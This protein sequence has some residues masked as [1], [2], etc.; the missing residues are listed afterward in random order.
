MGIILIHSD[1]FA[2]HQNPPGHP[3]R[4]ER[5]EV[6]DVVAARA[7]EAGLTVI[8]PRLATRAE[9]ARV[10]D[11]RYLRRIEE[12][13][14]HAVALD[15]DTFTSPESYE[16][17][18]LAAG[19]AALA[20][21]RVLDGSASAALAL[22]R[23]PGH[24]AERDRAMGFCL[25]NNVA[26]AAAHARTLGARRVAIVDY[27]VHHGNG[28]QH[29]FERDPDTLYVSTH[30]FPYYPG[31]GAADE[32]GEGAAAGATIN[33]PL[34]AGAVDD[35]YRVVF[36]EVIVPALRRFAPD[37]LLVSAGFD[38]HARDPLAGM[39]LT[40]GAFAA[41]TAELRAVAD[42]CCGGRTVLVTEGGYDL[43]ALADCLDAVVSVWTA[44]P[45]AP[46]WPAS[47]IASSRG[48]ASADAARRALAP[49]GAL[50]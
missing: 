1:R 16:I 9:L 42:A 32:V 44:P 38:A 27:D 7:R 28:T 11:E 2:E 24:H 17:A 13:A 31:T 37:L 5:A 21:E 19:S 36:Q 23:P 4:P 14:G 41:M 29:I 49:Y 22:V 10:H 12:T 18:R 45:A 39:R 47:G 8:E 40:T 15:P 48:R 25:F 30:Q 46:R 20:A 43:H 35:D 34:D 50:G 3:E 33:L 26:V 6:M